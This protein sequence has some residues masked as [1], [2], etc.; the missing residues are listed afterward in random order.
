MEEVY[1]EMSK[2]HYIIDWD[3]WEEFCREQLIDP[4]EYCDYGFDLGGGDSFDIEYVGDVPE[5]EKG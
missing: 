1:K 4:Y 5:R 3:V 2:V